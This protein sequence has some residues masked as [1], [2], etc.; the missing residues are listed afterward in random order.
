M[1][2]AIGS[3]SRWPSSRLLMLSSV[4][5][6]PMMVGEN[7]VPMPRAS[8]RAACDTNSCHQS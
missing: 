6:K 4:A 8:A 2:P 3:T 1:A 5:A 7:V